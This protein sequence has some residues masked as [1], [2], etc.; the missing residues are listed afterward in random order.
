M[1]P[2]PRAGQEP[3]RAARPRLVGLEYAV[4][5]R[6]GDGGA[7]PDAAAEGA[8]AGERRRCGCVYVSDGGVYV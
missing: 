7:E 3:W 6:Q 1:C 8:A 4:V 5:A 2:Y